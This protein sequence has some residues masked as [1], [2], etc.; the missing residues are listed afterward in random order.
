MKPKL[1]A[2]CPKC[3]KEA[4]LDGRRVTRHT[5]YSAMR[6]RSCV[7]FGTNIVVTDDDVRAWL[8]RTQEKAQRMADL[9]KER[10]AAA[11]RLQDLAGEAWAESE[12]L[13]TFVA[14]QL[15]KLGGTS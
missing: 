4:P 10:T 15:A 7:C 8:E 9:A 13:R 2:I 12:D 3:G 6:A 11:E 5:T 14:A 1:C